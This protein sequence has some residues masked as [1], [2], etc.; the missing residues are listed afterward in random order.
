MDLASAQA[1]LLACK[2]HPVQRI[3][4]RAYKEDAREFARSYTF[5]CSDVQL[6]APADQC[7]RDLGGGRCRGRVP[8]VAVTQAC[9]FH[10]RTQRTWTRDAVWESSA[11]DL[12]L[13]GARRMSAENPS[14]FDMTVQWRQG[15]MSERMRWDLYRG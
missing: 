3:L 13:D 11:A 7:R 2:D 15:Q 14:C 6:R 1:L 8:E 10:Q 4:L 12:N 5:L 9:A